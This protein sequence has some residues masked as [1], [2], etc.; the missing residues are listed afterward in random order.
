VRCGILL[1]HGLQSSDDQA[2]LHATYLR[3]RHADADRLA[4]PLMWML[5]PAACLRGDG[6]GASSLHQLPGAVV[7]RPTT[8]ALWSDRLL[9]VDCFTHLFVWSGSGVKGQEYDGA[10]DTCVELL[11]RQA[12]GRVPIPIAMTF[13]VLKGP[14]WWCCCCLRVV[15]C[16]VG[17]GASCESRTSPALLCYPCTHPPTD[18]LT[19]THTQEQTSASRYLRAR[20]SP[21]HHDALEVQVETMGMLARRSQQQAQALRNKLWRGDALSL[22]E[23]VHLLRTGRRR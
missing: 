5:D 10:R 13:Q 23:Y 16:C 22:R 8:L 15:L 1:G 20:L 11:Q 12:S 6:A 19:H 9:A 4:R 2:L 3:L 18:T 21:A 14:W 7:V 17:V